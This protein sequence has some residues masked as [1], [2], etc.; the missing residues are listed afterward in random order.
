M[1]IPLDYAPRNRAR[2]K[3]HRRVIDEPV[4]TDDRFLDE[5]GNL[6]LDEAGDVLREG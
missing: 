6:L 5:L 3:L 2:H 4:T 1:T